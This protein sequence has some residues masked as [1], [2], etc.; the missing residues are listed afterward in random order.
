MR[1][2]LLKSLSKVNT[3]VLEAHQD[4]VGSSGGEQKGIY[5]AS[6]PSA[7]L[8]VNNGFTGEAE[9][10]S[11]KSPV[12]ANPGPLLYIEPLPNQVSSG[13]ACLFGALPPAREE[14]ARL[15]QALLSASGQGW[16]S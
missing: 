15:G 16:E 2:G 12:A 8:R 3:S 11:W 10:Q 14:G 1:L 4:H 5:Q 7:L 6:L 9:G 13:A